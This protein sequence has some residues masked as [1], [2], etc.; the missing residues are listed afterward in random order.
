MPVIRTIKASTSN[1]KLFKIIFNVHNLS[2]IFDLNDHLN[3]NRH[4]IKRKYAKI[5]RRS[6]KNYMTI[7]SST[8]LFD[9]TQHAYTSLTNVYLHTW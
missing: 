5:I 8:P 7:K 3:E 9:N 1:V 6:S 4:K 2:G